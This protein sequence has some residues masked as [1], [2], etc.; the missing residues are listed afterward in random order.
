MQR[1]EKKQNMQLVIVES[2]TKARKIREYLGAEYQVEA[3]FGHVRDL[4]KK[5]LGVDLEHNFE[6]VYEVSEG[7]NKVLSLLK[8]LAKTAD[9]VILATDPDREG[10]AIAWHLKEAVKSGKFVRAV[11]HEITKQAVLTAIDHP[12]ELNLNLVDAQQARRVVDRLA[13]YQISPILW[14]KIRRGL[15]AGRVQ[16]VALR[17]I[18]E[19]EREIQAFKPQEYWELD[20]N[21]KTSANE[22]ITS[23]VNELGGKSYK[24]TSKSQ[25]DTVSA[26]LPEA[27]YRVLAVDK[28]ERKMST[29]PPFTTSTLQQAAANRLGMTSK[30]TMKLAQDLYEQGLITYHRTDSFFLSAAAVAAA[31]EYISAAYGADYIP[32]KPNYFAN[33]AKNAQEAHEAIRVTDA[34]KSSANLSPRHDKLYDLIRRRFLASQMTPAVY[35][36]TVISVQAK[37]NANEAIL[38][39]NG[40]TQKFAGWRQ[41]FPSSED[42]ILPSPKPAEILNFDQIMATQKFTQPPARYNDASL[43]KEL[44]KRGIGRP[45]TYAPTISLIEDRGYVERVEKKFF[46]TPIGITVCDFLIQHFAQLMQYE[47]TAKMEEDLDKIADGE[48]KWRQFVGNFYTDFAKTVETVQKEAE[49]VKVPVE[50]TGESCPECGEKDGGMLVI[51]SGKFGKFKSCSRFPECKYTENIKEIVAGLNCPVCGLGEVIAR[52]SRWGRV[53][54]GCSRYPECDWAAP[55]PPEPGQKLTAEEWEALKRARHE[56][57]Q[58]FRARFNKKGKKLTSSTKPRSAKSSTL[59]KA[60]KTARSKKTA[61][62]KKTKKI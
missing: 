21:L 34:K 19:K 40:S 15:S 20:V 54:Y 43:V 1:I 44:E 12:G 45:S 37:K 60:K 50:E 30:Q 31:R 10:E 38:K 4:P 36:Q 52:K 6:P 14:R 13:G 26:W 11:F 35:D 16:S 17:L 28:K 29:F 5:T 49:R 51:R 22:P 56:R 25:V 33:K 46:P 24:P 7:K 61:K 9:T 2:P 3:S 27:E 57:A 55:K 59:T 48:I 32:A 58:K 62:P 47:F 18:V 41:L 53:F 42:T 8:K 39:A 23:R